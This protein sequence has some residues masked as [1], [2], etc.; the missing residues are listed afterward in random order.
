VFA[1]QLFGVS[2]ISAFHTTTMNATT[3]LVK[4]ENTFSA[5]AADTQNSMA[6]GMG[7]SV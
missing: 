3:K 5:L 7:P 6:H 4:L 2:F 1:A